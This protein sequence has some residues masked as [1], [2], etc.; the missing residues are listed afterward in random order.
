MDELEVIT[1]SRDRAI[2]KLYV[3]FASEVSPN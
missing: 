2:L 1:K 3:A